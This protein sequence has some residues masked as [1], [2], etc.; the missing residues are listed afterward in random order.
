L[1]SRWQR[2]LCAGRYAWTPPTSTTYGVRE[3][4]D[5]QDERRGRRLQ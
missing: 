3:E 2:A 5:P 4:S 1:I